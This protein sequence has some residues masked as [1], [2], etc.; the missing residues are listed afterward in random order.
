MSEEKQEKFIDK[1]IYKIFVRHPEENN[2]TYIQHLFRAWSISF[3][4]SIALFALLIHGLIPS[5]FETTGTDCIKSLYEEIKEHEKVMKDRRE[6]KED[7][8]N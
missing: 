1:I 7:K 8:E 2:M 4:L 6:D 5:L 3:K